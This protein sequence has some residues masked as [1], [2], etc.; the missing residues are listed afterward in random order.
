MDQLLEALNKEAKIKK[1]R[2]QEQIEKLKSQQL[3]FLT[4]CRNLAPKLIP[5]AEETDTDKP[6][7][8]AYQLLESVVSN[9]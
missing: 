6:L 2:K 1:E 8:R 3:E 9:L 7:E 5:G 4:K